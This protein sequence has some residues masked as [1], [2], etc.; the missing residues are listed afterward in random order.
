MYDRLTN[1]HGLDNLIWV[2]NGEHAAFFPDNPATVDM[3]SFDYYGPNGQTNLS[4]KTQ[5]DNTLLMVSA[6]DRARMIVA[7]SENGVMPNPNRTRDEG[8]MWSW[9]MTRVNHYWRDPGINP[10]SHRRDVYNHPNVIT[11]E[12]LPDLTQYRLN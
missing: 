7:L 1:H 10:V 5:F 4:F 8:A 11:L 2:W 12:D 9:F 6:A 3:V